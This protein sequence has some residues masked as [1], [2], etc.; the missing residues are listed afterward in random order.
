MKRPPKK[1]A[2]DNLAT[3][4]TAELDLMRAV[5]AAANALTA[6]TAAIGTA[7]KSA[8]VDVSALVQDPSAGRIKQARIAVIRLWSALDQYEQTLLT[9][10]AGGRAQ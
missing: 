3:R 9:L 6:P 8:A 7:L 1:P 2:A 5:T 10:Q 4:P